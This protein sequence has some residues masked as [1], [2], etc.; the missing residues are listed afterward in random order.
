MSP[1]SLG[2]VLEVTVLL[3]STASAALMAL[4]LRAATP[5]GPARPT[6][7]ATHPFT[8]LTLVCGLVFLNQLAFNVFVRVAHHGDPEFI[9]RYIRGGWFD[10]VPDH[11]V[12]VGIAHAL[13]RDVGWLS[14]S[15]L[16][17]QAFLELPLVLFAYL[18]IARLLDRAVYRAL[19]QPGVLFAAAVAFTVPFD[20]VELSLPNPWTKDDLVVR[21]VACVVTPAWIA[22]LARGERGGPC[23]PASESRPTGL[24]GL[25]T[26]VTG[27]LATSYLVLVMYDVTLLYNLG[28]LSAAK[29]PLVAAWAAATLAHVGDG[30]FDG[31]VHRVVTGSHEAAPPA[32]LG[33]RVA[34]SALAAFT[35]LFF[36]PSLALRY[37]GTHPV[38][39]VFG[40]A[41]VLFGLVLGAVLALRDARPTAREIAAAGIAAIFALACGLVAAD[42]DLGGLLSA[43]DRFAEQLLLRKAGALLAVAVVAWVLAERALQKLL[44]T[45]PSAAKSSPSSSASGCAGATGSRSR[46]ACRGTRAR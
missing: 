30:R 35:F 2:A 43:R 9:A 45:S 32:P 14:P 46:A 6:R 5:F 4:R 34:T 39:Q 20:L 3:A 27:A 22:W 24:V 31:F 12:V 17:V 1:S 18:S 13:G 33:V 37:A 11:P 25:V 15:V 29:G 38:A 26:F 16:R 23:F 36:V 40:V 10:V 19:V 41:I 44:V 21:A 8:H 28:H 7:W 42:T